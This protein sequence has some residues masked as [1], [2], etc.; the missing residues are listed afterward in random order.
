MM[1]HAPGDYKSILLCK[2]V[3][4]GKQGRLYLLAQELHDRTGKGDW[5]GGFFIVVGGGAGPRVL[6]HG[7]GLARFQSPRLS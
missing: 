1:S 6:T 2:K 7:E 4:W 3:F 5:R